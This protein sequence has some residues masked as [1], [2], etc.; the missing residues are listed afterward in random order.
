[1]GPRISPATPPLRWGWRPRSW[2]GPW[3]P[4]RTPVSRTSWNS[5]TRTFVCVRTL[6]PRAGVIPGTSVNKPR[7]CFA[8]IAVRYTATRAALG[9]QSSN[10]MT[11]PK[12]PSD[13][14]EHHEQEKWYQRTWYQILSF[15]GVIVVFSLV[16]GLILNW[17]IDPQT[18]TQ[19]K[20]LVQALG[21]ITA[22]VAGAVGIFFTWRG[23]RQTQQSTQAE[24]RNA[25]EQLQL[26]RQGQ[27]TERFTRAIDQLGNASLEI[28]LGGI[29][30]LERIA[31]ESDED[32]WPIMEVLTAYVRQHAHWRPEERQGDKADAAVEKKPV[33]ESRGESETTEVPTPGPDV[34]AIMTVLRRRTRFFGREY[35][36][37]DLGETRLSGVRLS[38]A[39]LSGADLS[40][41]DLS[42]ANLSG[43][44]LSRADLS[45]ARL[46]EA[47]LV[48]A[49][50]WEANL[51]GAFLQRAN[52]SDARLPGADLS[53]ADLSDADLSGA[54]LSEGTRRVGN[55]PMVLVPGANLTGANLSGAILNQAQLEE[56]TGDET[57]KLPSYL[58]PP[59]HWGV[60][61][62]EQ[63]EGE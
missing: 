18:S 61:P 25:Q 40:G 16:L 35:E 22:G 30:A 19:K 27:I 45:G 53:E 56:T 23:Q 41:A 3:A 50:L 24:L 21:L 26:T 11:D 20:D 59:A 37:L 17:Y 62:D 28:R 13:R 52:L 33:E 44:N 48:H 31:K 6:N 7:I 12:P 43:A 2:V 14:D 58:K 5:L 10:E 29:Y 42:G 63:T 39:D 55:D 57:I 60:K 4:P 1:M 51:S 9:N 36:P 34:Q 38:G 47:D 32:H 49:S 15:V 46:W 54:G 8:I